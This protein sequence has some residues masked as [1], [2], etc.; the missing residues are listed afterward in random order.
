MRMF[1]V[2]LVIAVI[3]ALALWFGGIPYTDRTEILDV[4]DIEASVEQDERFDIAPVLGG[5]IL[6]VGLGLMIYGASTQ[7]KI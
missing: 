6:V 2:G 1:V 3:G 4:G 5:A 7:K